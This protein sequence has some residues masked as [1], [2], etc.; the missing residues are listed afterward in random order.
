[1]NDVIS[2]KGARENNLKNISLDIPKQKLVVLT[3][4]SGSGKS[5][6]ALDTLQRE[7]QR[8]YLDSMGMVS[9][10]ENKAR[11]ASIKGLS[12]SISVG[13]HVTN[14]SPR[15]TIGTVTDV[16]TLL[17]IVY[18]KL[19][20]RPCPSCGKSIPPAF[21]EARV[22]DDEEDM[23][24]QKRECPSC[25]HIVEGL[26][27]SHFSFNKPE[28][29]C[30][31]CSG[32][33]HTMDLKLETVFDVERSV[34]AG[35]VL[36]WYE[37]YLSYSLTNLQSAA[38]HYGLSFDAEKPIKDLSAP[39]RD[40]LFYG[41]ESEAFVAHFPDVAPPKTVGKGKFE[42]VVTGIWR[43]YQ[44]KGGGETAESAMF[45]EQLCP[46]C[47]GTKLKEESRRVKVGGTSID[48][49][50]SMTLKNA[51]AWAKNTTS[52]LDEDALLLAESL[53]HDMET[54]ISRLLQVGIGYMTLDRQVITLS[55]GES[56]RLRL[57]S[58]LGSGLTGVLYIL[59]EPTAGLHASDREAMIQVLKDLRDLGN[60]VLVIEHS[61][62]VIAAADHIIDMGPGAGS[63]GGQVIAEGTL[64]ELM[65]NPASVTGAVFKGRSAQERVQKRRKGIGRHILIEKASARNLKQVDV[66][67]PLGTM[68]SITGVSGSGKSTLMYEVFAASIQHGTAEGCEQLT[69]WP[70]EA[71]L[72]TVS[73][74]PIGRMQRS[75][76]A[77]F[78]DVY[79][80]MRKWFASF[81]EAKARQLTAKH[82]SFN[83]AGGRC[84]ECNG[85]GVVS[86]H[87]HFLPDIEVKCP[88][89]KGRRFK[90]EVL[91]VTYEGRNIS[92]LL[93]MTVED[94]L[95]ILQGHPKMLAATSLLHD[96]GLGYLQWGQSLNTLSGG[97]GQRLKLA[98]ELNKPSKQHSVY[99]LDEPTTGLHMV[100]VDK[101]KILLDRLVDAGNT[102]ILVEH[103][104]DL[105]WQ[106]DWVIDIGP[107]GGEEGGQVVA[108]G[109][110]EDIVK[111]PSSLT[112][113]YLQ[114]M[115]L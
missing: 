58:V 5:T 115:F 42:G 102:V 61:V 28:G 65:N 106:S 70:E 89:C 96:V 44:E 4:P 99:V 6:L 98:K 75:N 12:P 17:R 55:G 56:Q 72:V 109:T 27:M 83:T 8:Q 7:C 49:I 50:S 11:V 57:A 86:I 45:R 15:S 38:K 66:A 100:D 64:H 62:D 67:L 9:P 53:L 25:G 93:D 73:Q 18:A 10:W 81:P 3:G 63:Q 80:Q 84:E 77:T 113:Q 85:L 111:E 14:R 34:M 32:L 43:R 78:T 103:H 23:F 1:M 90:Q 33:G 47:H 82:F 105:I 60:T 41:V 112:G 40:L 68:M 76:V 46:S 20:I 91:E 24:G 13:Q 79:T 104:L 74:S 16:Y 39:Q 92:D 36:I 30:G 26:T 101:L 48:Q 29:A 51:L 2:I 37:G 69:G 108:I 35:G 87:M 95:D 114:Q 110:P 97:E 71:Q 107:G 21:G 52:T 22:A 54:R 94:S 31:T 59:D 19:G 88:V